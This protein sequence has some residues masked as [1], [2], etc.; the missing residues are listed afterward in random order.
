MKI[1]ADTL[2]EA[3]REVEVLVDSNVEFNEEVRRRVTAMKLPTPLKAEFMKALKE[4]LNPRKVARKGLFL[5]VTG[6]DKAGKETQCFNPHKISGVK[7]VKE[8]LTEIGLN[9]FSISLPSYETVL[10]SLVGAYLKNGYGDVKIE[11]EVSD[12]YA[13]ILWSLDRAQHNGLIRRWLCSEKSSV[14]AKR[15]VES[16]LCYQTVRGVSEDRI[17]KFERNI[18]KPDLTLILDITAEEAV[19]RA[20]MVDRYERLKFLKRVR[21]R[22][23]KLSFRGLLG[24]SV[25]VN[26][27]GSPQEVNGRLL[28][29]LNLYLAHGVEE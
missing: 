16:N 8:F 22:L 7:P 27:L 3:L 12:D 2:N 1:E 21:A 28:K 5:V 24:R 13:W 14:L 25:V 6:I 15:W 18:E 10:G 19:K 23:L 9:V 29:V 17:L 4:L 11:G 20:S 26:G